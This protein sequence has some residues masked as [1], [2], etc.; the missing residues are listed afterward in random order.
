MTKRPAQNRIRGWAVAFWLLV[1]QAAA[2]ALDA[3]YLHG[4]LLLPTPISALMRLFELEQAALNDIE[5]EKREI[6]IQTQAYMKM[7]A[8][9]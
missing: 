8:A 3:L 1:W 5:H 4:Q 7:I 2:M 6:A 9:Q